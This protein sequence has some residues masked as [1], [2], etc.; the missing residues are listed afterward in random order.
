MLASID[1]LSV[2]IAD[3]YT[4]IEARLAPFADTV[5]RLDEIPG[6]GT[7]AVIFAE[8][9]VE[10]TRFPI[11]TRLSSCARFAPGVKESAGSKK[12]AGVTGHRDRY[13]PRVLGDAVVAAARTLTFLAERYQRIARLRG[14]KKAIVA[15]GRSIRLIVW[16]LLS[17]PKLVTTT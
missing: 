10:M 2:D 9:G 12:G 15:V 16:S 7:A 11:P 6:A 4:K 13:L 8:V 14:K 17:D 1:A 3:L 5:A